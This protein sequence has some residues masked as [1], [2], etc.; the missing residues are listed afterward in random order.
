MEIF[1]FVGFRGFFTL[2]LFGLHSGVCKMNFS[3]SKPWLN[4]GRRKFWSRYHHFL[5]SCTH[6]KFWTIDTKLP[7]DFHE[8]HRG[9]SSP[10]WPSHECTPVQQNWLT[11]LNLEIRSAI[12]WLSLPY[13]PCKVSPLRCL[14]PFLC[15]WD[16]CWFPQAHGSTWHGGQAHAKHPS[17]ALHL[18]YSNLLKTQ[19]LLAQV[20]YSD[21]TAGL[22]TECSS[23]VRTAA[24]SPWHAPSPGTDMT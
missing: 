12:S 2:K 3:I 13:H 23:D 22:H 14:G 16:T 1:L 8:G 10:N 18:C 9:A 6:F 7:R 17:T 19:G 15:S 5:T 24:S 20:Q 11:P 4:Q 21:T